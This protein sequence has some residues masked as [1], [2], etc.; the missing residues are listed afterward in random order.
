MSSFVPVLYNKHCTINTAPKLTSSLTMQRGFPGNHNK[1]REDVIAKL[2]TVVASIGSILETGSILGSNQTCNNSIALVLILPSVSSITSLPPSF[3]LMS[4]LVC[5]IVNDFWSTYP[6]QKDL[7]SWMIQSPTTAF[8]LR[9]LLK[10]LL[11]KL[12][13]SVERVCSQKTG[14]GW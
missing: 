9:F 14:G 5:Q 6:H 1:D 2:E 8:S 3:S 12:T 10:G 13:T 11:R 4:S 7:S